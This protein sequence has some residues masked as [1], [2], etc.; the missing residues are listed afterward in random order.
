MSSNHLTLTYEPIA[1]TGVHIV[2]I[3]ASTH[4]E[5][6]AVGL[7]T[8]FLEQWR[9]NGCEYVVVATTGDN[10]LGWLLDTVGFEV[11]EAPTGDGDDYIKAWYDF[12]ELPR[13]TQPL[14]WLP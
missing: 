2:E 1:T 13:P 11:L 7:F 4:G 12:S 8:L 9:R 3:N 10:D 5:T 14:P 6:T